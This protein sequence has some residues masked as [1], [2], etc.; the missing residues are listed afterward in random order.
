MKVL[1]FSNVYSKLGLQ[2]GVQKKIAAQINVFKSSGLEVYH[3]CPQ[4]DDIYNI[5][6]ADG[7]V[8]RT[9]DISNIRGPKKDNLINKEVLQFIKEKEINAIY[10]R[11]GNYSI[12]ML[13]F[14]K[15]VFSIGC[16]VVIEIAT[17]P[18]TQRKT[19]IKQSLKLKK[20]KTA[21]SQIYTA[22][23]GSLGIFWLHKYVHRIVTY[24]GYDNIW[25][26]ETIK[27]P[28]SVDV[29]AMKKHHIAKRKEGELHLIAVANVAKWHG[30]DRIIAGMGNFYHSDDQKIKVTFDIIGPGDEIIELK[31]LTNRL[32]VGEFVK[33]K[34]TIVGQELDDC[35]E[36]AD[37][38]VSVLGAHR[39]G[40]TRYDSLKSREYCA[41]C[42]PFI[43]E[44]A[45]TM[46]R[47]KSFVYV[48]DNNEL[49]IDIYALISFYDNVCAH[50]EKI[51]KEIIEYAINECDWKTTFL[52]VVRFLNNQ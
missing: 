27:V 45:E 10:V 32:G 41:R 49:P 39:D 50:S 44:K 14:Y 52:P 5:I 15:K 47:N 2:P 34:G 40:M 36:Y 8:L 11:N 46:Y 33:F 7:T 38:A 42:I 24:N 18:L 30:Y 3:A 28:N 48:M 43:T 19:N 6:D 9:F 4:D 20:Y 35:F 13:F 1:Y 17:Y 29:S 21:L 23:I 16:K 12:Q 22:T 31:K 26:I 37:V 25:G 51:E